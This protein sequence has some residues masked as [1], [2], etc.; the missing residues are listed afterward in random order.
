MQV[1]D[2]CLSR[3][4]PPSPTTMARS[5]CTC[6]CCL[7]CLVVATVVVAVAVQ[8][9]QPAPAEGSTFLLTFSLQMIVS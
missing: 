9:L 5:C 1:S 3:D 4:H 8:L 2:T 7:V 6:N